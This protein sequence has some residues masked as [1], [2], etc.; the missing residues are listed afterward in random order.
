MRNDDATPEHVLE[1]LSREGGTDEANTRRVAAAAGVS[2]ARV[3]GA[4]HFYSLLG[5]KSAGVRVCQGLSCRLA[6]SDEI[7]D[8][9]RDRG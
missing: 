6:G 4:G 2:E 8:E 5:S 3:W 9:L 7:C 1:L